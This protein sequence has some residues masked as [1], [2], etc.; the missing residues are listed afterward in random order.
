MASFLI[1]FMNFIHPRGGRRDLARARA[2]LLEE[3]RAGWQ[4]CSATRHASEMNFQFLVISFFLRLHHHK[5]KHTRYE[6][7]VVFVFGYSRGRDSVQI[8]TLGLRS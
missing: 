1:F 6:N 5:P 2:I 8:R 4:I 7:I 3:S